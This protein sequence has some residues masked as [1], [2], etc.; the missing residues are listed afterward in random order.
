[1]LTGLLLSLGIHGLLF[2]P[3]SEEQ[4]AAAP[5][6]RGQVAVTLNLVSSRASPDLTESRP[7]PA[8]AHDD[9]ALPDEPAGLPVAMSE[10]VAPKEAPTDPAEPA[11]VASAPAPEVDGSL[12]EKGV[13]SP[14]ELAGSCRPEYPRLSRRL[15]EEGTVTLEAE[16][17]PD[18]SARQIRV[19]RS[20]GYKRLDRSALKA[21]EHAS[22][23]PAIRSGRQ[24]E[25]SEEFAFTFRLEGET[26]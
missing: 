12:L 13:S 22:F 26:P 9:P 25:S 17:G 8:A 20:S 7:D 5:F 16:I 15:G 2:W 3:S 18:G 19:V 6:D 23:H 14:A 21:M 10:T 24:V 1:M 11:E 4:S